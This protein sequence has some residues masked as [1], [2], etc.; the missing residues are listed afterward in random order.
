MSTPDFDRLAVDTVRCLAMDA[1]QAAN[2]GHPGTPMALAPVAH[3]LWEHFLRFD[4]ENDK[5]PARDR[6]VLSAG[7]ASMLLYGTLFLRSQGL[8]LDDLKNFRQLG[9]PCAGHPE[10]GHCPGVETTTGPL[11][12]GIA[13][14][15]GMAMAQA[16]LAARY[17]RPGHE[18][19][20]WRT[21]ALCGD[22]DL[23]E[24]LS[25]EAASL[26]GHLGL[27]SLTWIYDANRI[28]IEGSTDLAFTE[29]VEARFR[30][31]AW[32]V[33]RLD[34]ANDLVALK[35]ALERA[36]KR[37]GKPGLIIVRSHI[38][39]GSPNMQD[40]ADAHG[41]PL[42][43]E[44][45]K[46][47]K[48]AYGFDPERKFHVP[49]GLREELTRRARDR[50]QR[51]RRQFEERLV[52]YRG[53]FPEQ[54]AELDQFFSGRLPKGWDKDLP[55]FPADEKGM[56]GRAASGKT[57]NVLA[58]QL[59]WLLGGSADLA[60]SNKTEVA[61]ATSLSRDHLGG[62]N[63][64]FGVREHAMGAIANGMAL[65]G[66]RP[67]TGTFFV[68]SDYMR[69]VH[70]L[71]G[72]MQIP[73]TWV[74]THDSIGVGEDGPTHQPVEHLPSL[75]AIPGIDVLRPGDANEVVEAWR[76]AMSQDRR[77]AALVL[78]RQN[79]PTLDR[80]V[81]APASGLHRGAY[82]LADSPGGA[83]QVALMASG[84]ELG[85]AVAA[86]KALT[87]EGIRARV[88]SFPCWELF[89]RQDEVYRQE[90]LPDDLHARV[91]ME[92]ASPFGWERWVGRHG[93]VIAQRGF[94]ASAPGSQL[95]EHFGFTTEAMVSA[96]KEQIARHADGTGA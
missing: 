42:G 22:G 76:H 21:V 40:T 49:D 3:A 11:G 94:G 45:I 85:T 28:T 68:F 7:H 58:K 54:A 36:R 47:T 33:E 63:I 61:G 87:A 64:H 34:D 30:A 13:N 6:F 59:P 2:S 72:L 86:W 51:F 84:T 56:A 89:E 18:I 12:Q 73:V 17:N 46:L 81:F 95:F 88:I 25:Y 96:A 93:C 53:A 5:H 55:V 41:A 91:A 32:Q 92:A 57:L 65:S 31:M 10:Y 29:D 4:A 43:E 60:G 37:K 48:K 90:V 14:S 27:G 71:A 38:A 69:P 19:I 70:R 66:L 20:D 62:R 82:V 44:E 67:Y 24:G 50:G 78:S 77:P 83:P 35:G 79:H 23:M 8:S 26:A 75:R 39:F 1:V 9:S 52:A 74:Y 15:V 80:T 16:W